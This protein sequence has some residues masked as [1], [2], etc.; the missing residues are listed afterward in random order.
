[1]N[2][3]TDDR[4][5]DAT[6]LSA[7]LDHELEPAERARVDA[8]LREHPADAE[9]VRRWAA[10]RDAL[11]AALQP[12]LAE[13]VPERL[14]RLVLDHRAARAPWAAW[15]RVAMVAVFAAGGAL[16]ASLMWAVQR[17]A[18]GAPPGAA[19]GPTLAQHDGWVQRA[20][21]AH[22]VY[23]PE[24]RHPVEV[25]VA[26]GPEGARAAQEQHLQRW[27][28]KRVDVPVP[29][30]DLRAQ[31]FELVGGRLLPDEP[32]RPCAMLMYQHRD[33]QRVTVYLRKASTHVPAEF[34][35]ER[36]GDVGLFYWVEGRTGY[37]L[38]GNLGREQLL[39]LAQAIYAQQQ[40]AR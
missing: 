15:R 13:P 11:A 1:M 24:I 28:T 34:R 29:L 6:Q 23:V 25:N 12:L 32:G 19:P 8:W 40:G 5:V 4:P 7:W 21:L 10:D 3:P 33:G 35:Y 22:R 39:A 30:F 16:G 9:T 20:A 17:Q 14:R 18:S 31:G 27:L 36:E 26:E 37:A 2:A 38:A